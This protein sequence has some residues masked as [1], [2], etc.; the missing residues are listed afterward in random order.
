MAG[1]GIDEKPLNQFRFYNLRQVEYVRDKN[2]DSAPGLE[3]P[4]P[5]KCGTIKV[6]YGVCPVNRYENC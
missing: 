2:I 6:L 5:A 1:P 3:P 4:A